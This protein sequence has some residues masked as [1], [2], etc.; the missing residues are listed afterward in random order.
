M[1]NVKHVKPGTLLRVLTR[2]N[3]IV[4]DGPTL[5]INPN[6]DPNMF[7]NRTVL[8]LDYSEGITIFNG[9]KNSKTAAVFCV[10]L[11]VILNDKKYWICVN[12]TS[13]TDVIELPDDM[14]EDFRK[15]GMFEIVDIDHDE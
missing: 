2:P 7:L 4:W 15:T 9:F 12:I 3:V 14:K 10:R 13:N 1:I 8:V 5:S 11:L 6:I